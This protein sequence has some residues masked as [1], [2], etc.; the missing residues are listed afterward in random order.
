[1]FVL[2]KITARSV[3]IAGVMGVILKSEQAGG[4]DWY[5]RHYSAEPQLSVPCE[6]TPVFTFSGDDITKHLCQVLV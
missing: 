2:E 4:S 1:M 6:N 3:N 5:R